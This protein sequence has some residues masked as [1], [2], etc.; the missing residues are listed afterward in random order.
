M[1]EGDTIHRLARRLGPAL[2]GRPIVRLW[3]R[4][5]GEV[6]ALCGANVVAVEAVGKHLLVGV[7]D[8]H[9]LH[10]HLGMPGRVRRTAGAP[11]PTWDTSAIVETADGAVV[12]RSA[13]TAVLRRRDDPGF[14][15]AMQRV[16]PDL[17]APEVDLDEVVAR[18]YASSDAARPLVDVLL[19]QSIAAGIGNVFKSEVL[20]ACGLA[21]TRGLATVE[22]SQLRDAYALARVMLQQGARDGHRDTVH[23]VEPRRPRT[24]GDHLWV[25]DRARRPC[26]R[27]GAAIVRVALGVDRRGTYLCPAC[28]RDPA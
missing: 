13:R 17:L 8:E 7:G 20:F 25:Y 14:V 16:G 18:A 21:P 9:V 3:V 1:P 15:R 27:C 4:D 24:H 26:L 23:V 11:F 6:P 12:W 5:R 10:T 19:D 2:V 22:R 28:Q